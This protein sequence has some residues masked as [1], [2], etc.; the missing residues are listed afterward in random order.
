MPEI[1]NTGLAILVVGVFAAWALSAILV[2]L[3]EMQAAMADVPVI[4]DAA[5][6]MVVQLR[7]ATVTD[8]AIGTD[9]A[10]AVAQPSEA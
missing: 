2:R 6:A 3:T 4:E 9:A 10:M 7:A 5:T 1:S 8:G